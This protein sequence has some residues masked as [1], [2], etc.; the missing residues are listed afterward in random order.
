MNRSSEVDSCRIAPT[1]FDYAGRELSERK[2]LGVFYT[3]DPLA[4]VL[5]EWALAGNAGP[6]LDPSF[7][8]CSFLRAALDCLVSAGI[9]DGARFIHGVDSDEFGGRRAA[10]ELEAIGVPT[11]HFR[12]T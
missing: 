6:I 2:R 1:S 12:Y 5:A 8:G 4:R 3:P 10:R 11:I 9:R 7:G